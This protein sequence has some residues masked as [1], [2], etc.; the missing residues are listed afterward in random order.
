MYSVF[1]RA[2]ILILYINKFFAVRI[3]G[4]F[5]SAFS[6]PIFLWLTLP[7]PIYLRPLGCLTIS[8]SCIIALEELLLWQISSRVLS[9]Y[10]AL[11]RFKISYET[12]C[13]VAKNKFV[14]NIYFCLFVYS[15]LLLYLLKLFIIHFKIY[16]Q[17]NWLSF[18]LCSSSLILFP[19][20]P[21]WL[22]D[23]SKMCCFISPIF[24]DF[25]YFFLLLISSLILL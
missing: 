1:C 14:N 9:L 22:M 23:C 25:P 21:L 11:K 2:P 13:L 12:I 10:C 8:W 19:T 24:G 4:A 15:N 5:T 3:T 17:Q 20:L 18:W 7:F 16:I 6:V